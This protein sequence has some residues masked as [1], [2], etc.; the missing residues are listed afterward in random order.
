MLV[1]GSCVSRDAFE[2]FDPARFVLH[3]YHARH[4]LI[5]AFTPLPAD[6]VADARLPS[7]F[8]RR[9]LTEDVTAAVLGRLR[10]PGRRPDLVLWDLVDERLGVLELPD[11]GFLTVSNELLA[12][13]I[14]LP[15]G[16]AHVPFGSDRHFALW[17][18]AV[19]AFGDLLAAEDLSRR[20]VLLL[21][22]WA[23][24]TADG[25][26]TPA[27]HGVTAEEGNRRYARYER[28]AAAVPGVSV[29]RMAPDEAVASADH[30]WGPAPFHYTD[31]FYRLVAARVLD[32]VSP[33]APA[34]PARPA[35]SR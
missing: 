21:A 23:T 34:H 19:A 10:S 35:A 18:R 6:V 26:P 9:M 24:R 13:G 3:S 22:P 2:A 31:E 27:S 11:G 17:S 14:D 16:T 12:A 32:A 30:R 4:S 28:A 7:A 5:S 1:L 29:V 25:R 8:Q 20:T 15:A 33:P